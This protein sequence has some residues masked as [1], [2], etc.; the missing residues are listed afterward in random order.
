MNK[1]I[2]IFFAID[3]GYIPFLAVTLQSVIENANKNY[4]YAIRILHTNVKKENIDKIKNIYESEK[5]SIEF[6]DLSKEIENYFYEETAAILDLS[7]GTVKSRLSRARIQL[8]KIL[9]QDKEP[10]QSFFVSNEV[11]KEQDDEL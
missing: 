8:K 1:E 7:V 4:N 2:P 11:D 3:N 9:E 6:V 10:Y 5:V